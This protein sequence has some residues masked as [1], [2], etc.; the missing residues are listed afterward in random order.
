MWYSL[1]FSSTIE[2]GDCYK[3]DVYSYFLLTNDI[4][5]VIELTCTIQKLSIDWTRS[6]CKLGLLKT[7]QNLDVCFGV[8]SL[9]RLRSI[10]HRFYNKCVVIFQRTLIYF[11]SRTK[12]CLIELRIRMHY[13]I[14]RLTRS[15]IRLSFIPLHLR[16]SL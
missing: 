7:V 11:I 3:K 10:I 15:W 2:R 8:L 16:F 9:K 5:R 14:V 4:G 1:T 13:I 12:R 6:P